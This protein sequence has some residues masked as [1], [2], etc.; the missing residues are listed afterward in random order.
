MALTT[1]LSYYWKLDEGSGNITDEVGSNTGTYNGALYSQT[2]KIGTSIGFTTNDY[3]S[4]SDTSFLT[5][6]QGSLS[7]W[8]YPTTVSGAHVIWGVGDDSSAGT[9]FWYIAVADGHISYANYGA[10]WIGVENTGTTTM[11]ANNWY[12]IIMTHD[13][14]T[15]KFYINGI[16]QSTSVAV[17]SANSWIDDNTAGLD[18]FSI[19]VVDRNGFYAF[20]E[21]DIDEAG[22]WSRALTDGGVA[23]GNT[24]TGEVA[25]LYNSGDGFTYPFSTATDYYQTCS[26][27][28]SSVAWVGKNTNRAIAEDLN[29]SDGD[30]KQFY[31]TLSNSFSFSPDYEKAWGVNR[32]KTE[33]F[34]LV[35]IKLK[36]IDRLI[37][38]DFEFREPQIKLTQTITH[39]GETINLS[40]DLEILKILFKEFTEGFNFSDETSK[41]LVKSLSE[42]TTL[43]DEIIKTIEKL[44][45]E[46]TTLSDEKTKEILRS[47]SE[48]LTLNDGDFKQFIRTLSDSFNLSP[49]YQKLWNLN[50]DKTEQIGLTDIK[51]KEIERLILENINLSPDYQKLW[52]LNR[53]KTEQINLT[54]EKT[55]EMGRSIS[56]SL[57]FSEELNKLL[58]RTFNEN[59]SLSEELNK[60]FGKIFSEN[61][62][63]SEEI[64]K[65]LERIFSESTT[66]SDGDFKE[67]IKILSNSFYLS[68]VYERV[69]N[70]ERKKT[71][72]INLTEIQ[73]KEINR[74][75][76]EEF[77]FEVPKLELRSIFDYPGEIINLSDTLERLREVIRIYNESLSFSEEINKEIGRSLNENIILSDGDSKQFYR[78]LSNSF[79]FSPSY[80]RVWNID[81]EKT[82][83]ISL[84]DIKTN[85]IQRSILE[86][87]SASDEY[88]K[89]WSLMREYAESLDLTDEKTK[90]IIKLISEDLNLTDEVLTDIFIYV[91]LSENYGL[92]EEFLKS[93]ERDLSEQGNLNETLTKSLMRLM[94][95]NVLLSETRTIKPGK[96]LIENILLSDGDARNIIRIFNESTNINGL[97]NKEIQRDFSQEFSF[98]ETIEKENQKI[99]SESMNLTDWKEVIKVKVQILLESLGLVDDF[100]RIVDFLRIYSES[101]SIS[102]K[103]IK[104]ITNWM[105]SDGVRTDVQSIIQEQGII[106]TLIRQTGSIDE[107]GGVTAVS[108]EEYTIYMAAQDILRSDRQIRDMGVAIPGTERVFMFHSYPDS[109]TG[110]GVLVPQVGD[111]IKDDED[112]NWR[113]EEITAEHEMDGSEIFK[114][115]II[116]KVDLNQ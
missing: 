47:I 74:N 94:T 69:W 17:G 82:E 26:E 111:L 55:K 112:I 95:E 109:I 39:P 3:I 93:I 114:S 25:E 83:N 92:T 15:N 36:E 86:E 4:L 64:T 52:N 63:L 87:I 35:D 12:H 51:L 22:I 98:S 23:V 9:P 96:N 70:L 102:D 50:R 104:M 19:G 53:D 10:A 6:T 103:F 28:F 1:N 77:E 16:R 14:T 90:E 7:A 65:V 80:E 57:S 89:A 73:L 100:D 29:F 62:A 107:M 37:S 20:F 38:E 54:D 106:A 49:D 91:I 71:E 66:L 97:I 113:V 110:N 81:R 24:A 34:G 41:L 46:N 33:Q 101:L 31:K 68:E 21:G 5:S 75:I 2:G 67:F 99:F 115:V 45:S 48:N 84:V 32:I 79:N 108:E 18:T 76:L 42:N 60:L 59:L 27:E 85:A 116:K 43:S 61:I 105:T 56:E 72:Q 44:L 30:S 78:I 13:G 8:I 40:E 88:S 58:E 11:T